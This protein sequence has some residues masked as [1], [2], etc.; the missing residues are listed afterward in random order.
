M[1]LGIVIDTGASVKSTARY[2]QFQAL[3]H[4]NPE[5]EM[6]LDTSTKGQA[7]VQFGIGSAISIGSTKVPTPIGEVEFHIVE[8]STP[9]LLCLAD[10][11]RLQ[12]YYDN[13]K[14]VLTTRTG[15]IPVVRRFGHA[16]LMCHSSLY[17]YI[18]ESF[19]Q[20]PCYLTE[21]ELRRLHLR[22]GH[23]SVR[24]LQQLL[25]R[26]G[27]E[28]NKE[29]LEHLTKY[30]H[31]CQKHG[32][33]PGRFRFTLQDDVEFNYNIIVDVMYIDNRPVLHVVDE[34]TRFQAGRWLPNISA[35]TTW[36]V[37]KMCWID[38]YLGPPDMITSDAG[39][40]FASKEFKEYAGTMGIR[41]KVM[42]VEAHNSV[43]MVER[44]HGPLRRAYQIIRTELPDLSEEAV[45]QMAFKAINDTAGP[46]G[47]VP[48]LLLFGAYPRMTESDPPSGTV[49]QRANA[50]KKAMVEIRKLRAERQVADALNQRNGPRV[51]DIHDLPPSSPVLVWREGNG[52]QSGQWEGPF[53]LV[54]RENETCMVR[55]KNTLTPF[56]STVVKPYL[57]LGTDNTEPDT[58]ANGSAEP[59][60]QPEVRPEQA[61]QPQ[62]RRPG[63]PRKYALLM[64]AA[65]V[66]VHL[67]SDLQDDNHFIGQFTAEEHFTGQFA[68][69]RQKELTGLL[70]K[71]VF[72]T[73]TLTDVPEGKRLLNSRFVDEIK[74]VGTSKAFEKSRLV[75]QAYNDHEKEVVL[76]QSPTIQRVSQRLILC[77]A[78][79]GIGKFKLYLRDISQAYVQSTTNLNREIYARPPKEL[80][81]KLGLE[82]GSILKVL[83]P[84]YGVPEAG[85]HWFRT[86]HAH[87]KEHLR[88]EE[89]TY[90][91]C[92]LQSNEPFGV[93]G[94]QTDDTLFLADE[95]FAGLEQEELH[96]ASFLAKEREELTAETPLKFNG[97]LIQLTPDGITLTQERQ[98]NNLSTIGTKVAASTGT[99]GVTRILTPKDQYIAQRARGAYI[100]SVCQP[101]ASCDLSFAA[102]VVNPKE[103][104]AKALNKRLAWQIENSDRGLKFVKLDPKTLQLV[105]FTDASFANNKDLSS[106]TY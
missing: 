38:S 87:H 84:L 7:K 41:T 16:F 22:F 26:A 72:E 4:A 1:F 86:Y 52:G 67:Q 68:A 78:A 96:K 45:L 25:D 81:N 62:K 2:D 47:L 51:D 27:H 8:S 64:G 32:K 104:D 101:E 102:Q 28:V 19:V 21:V 18:T 14:D 48:T 69:S 89:S 91:P 58:G 103:D 54:S 53:T 60:P 17:S 12:V 82:E 94:L 75:I 15:T 66:T 43:G 70:E 23:P 31:S 30:C 73:V 9:F 85:N 44:Y 88:M 36:D 29:A 55:I 24:R 95:G 63:R 37:L 6:T 106:L 35:K 99:R 71:G 57:R 61:A 100:A 83:K 79:M 74:H 97:G 76:T 49:M 3:Q 90:D 40:N 46:E 56:R 92:L 59:T 50:I 77:L 10:M 13:T 5:M 93:V 42:P 105:V 11:D 20:N 34:A 65:D 80:R 39:K 98:C 33:S